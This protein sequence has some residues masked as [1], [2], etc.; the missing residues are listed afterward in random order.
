MIRMTLGGLC[1]AL[2]LA[3]AGWL[4]LGHV[5]RERLD[6][7]VP[8]LEVARSV[9]I[10]PG[11]SLQA[12]A[13]SLSSEGLLQHPQSFVRE[14]RREQLAGRIRAGE[15]LVEPGT[16]PRQMLD[17]FVAGRVGLH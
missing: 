9:V 16:T 10:M 15:Y 17:M 12:V 11:S 1:L 6:E 5:D 2:L 4:W 7:P 3:G 8:G 14:A 13:R